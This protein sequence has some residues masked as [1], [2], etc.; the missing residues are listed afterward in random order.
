MGFK[1]DGYQPVGYYFSFTN[2]F[3][4]LDGFDSIPCH[5][6]P[7]VFPAIVMLSATSKVLPICAHNFAYP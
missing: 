1:V 3:S 7:F 2:A 4:H 6:C 5:M